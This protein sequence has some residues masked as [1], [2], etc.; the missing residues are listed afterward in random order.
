MKDTV[1]K[2]AIILTI[3]GLMSKLF[4]ALFRLPLTNIVG[5]DG[6][7]IFQMV[8]T[9]YSFAVVFVS[10]GVTNG[11]AKLVSSA[12]ARGDQ[13]AVGSYLKRALIFSIGLSLAFGVIFILF[14]PQI[15]LVQGAEGTSALYRLLAAL[16]PLGAL[17]GVF[18][19]IIQGYGN[20]APT[21][22]SQIIEQ[23]IKFAFGLIFAYLFSAQ[24]VSGGV[25]G[26]I[27]GITISEIF[28]CFY[29]G[30]KIFK[31]GPYLLTNEN[32][33]IFYKTTLPLT[34]G[35]I[36]LPFTHTIEALFIVKLLMWSGLDQSFARA[37]YGLQTG[38]VGAILNF[39]LIISVA[40]SSALLPNLSFFAERGDDERQQ[41]VI[42]KSLSTMWFLLIPLVFGIVSI[43]RNVYPIIYPT[44]IS[45]HL[46]LAEQLTFI[47][48]FSIICTALM[49][50]LVSI[51][52]ANG[53]FKDS[54]I[55]YIIGG[56]S[57][58]ASLVLISCIEG[59]APFA[60]GI[61]N[62][63]L[64][65]IVS[66][67]VIIKLKHLIKLPFF[68]ILLPILSAVVMFIVVRIILNLIPAIWGIVFAIFAG[69][70]VYFVIAYPLTSKYIKIMIASIKKEVK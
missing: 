32:K 57:K 3:S 5:L 12:R 36:I 17:V 42:C 7:A 24:S 20:M 15:S 53:H 64:A 22:V 40:L 60:M 38:V 31:L 10:G 21:A 54:L 35:G 55:F 56:V 19:G 16:L 43:S 39:P 46:N 37:I 44:A 48:G 52:Q 26:A 49:Q 50:Q 14:A 13:N 41:K 2:G 66:M 33:K 4:G 65:S 62:L 51:L 1:G 47:N 18:R 28:A 29:L 68:E 9:I 23:V 8:M 30:V 58:L 69:T 11:L 27:L 59:V 45:E 6:I 61:S 63:V 25:F 34:F 67:C 70:I